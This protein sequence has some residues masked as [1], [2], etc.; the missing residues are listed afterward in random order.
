MTRTTA[1]TDYHLSHI[2]IADLP[3]RL[4][5]RTAAA[6]ITR[7][8]FPISPRTLEVW[9]VNWRLVNGRA[10]AE[11]SE[12]LSLAAAKLAAAASVRGG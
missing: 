11:T 8:F 6:V 7:F 9:P 10:L 2:N 5:R 1:E 4:D 3:V 12:L